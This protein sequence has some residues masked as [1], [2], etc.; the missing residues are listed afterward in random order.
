MSKKRKRKLKKWV[1]VFGL[2]LVF[3]I[4]GIILFGFKF[5]LKNDN[6][7]VKKSKIT[8]TV[9]IEKVKSNYSHYVK[10]SSDTKLFDKKNKVVGSLKKDAEIV[11]DDSYKIEDEFYKLSGCEFFVEYNKVVKV[12]SLKELAHNE[13]TTY[14]NYLPYNLNIITNDNY[15]LYVGEDEYYDLNS[16]KEYS[17]IVKDDDKYGVVFN[18]RLVY[19]NKTDVKLEK[20]SQNTDKKIN[21]K[22]PVLNY[23][24]TVSS[25]NENG[26]LSECTQ[27]I[28]MKDTQ[29]EEEIKYLK[30]NGYYAVTMRDLYLFL[31]GKVRLPEKSVAITIDDG[32]Y[33]PRM[34]RILEKYQMIGTLF[35]I[36]SLASPNDYKSNYL[37]V[38]SHSWDM[39]TPGVCKGVHGGAILCWDN[40]KILE[41]LKKSRESLNNSTVFCYPFYEY[42]DNA[43]NMLKEAGFQMAFIGGDKKAYVG[44][45]M[46]KINRYELVNYTKMEEFIN[47]VS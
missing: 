11:L 33:L 39:H 23:H 30:D 13:Y 19:I 14:K 29:V 44:T 38:H 22:I 8:K 41:D 46:Y 45:D 15:K 3:C 27:S 34:I 43:I 47:Y 4:L 35:L 17:V 37:E 10:V 32:W 36:G 25:T 42:N 28:C 18:D 21:D 2:I 9:D 12:D 5:A 31:S 7:A 1:K 26:E 16:E 24:Y 40:N 6:Y 20:E